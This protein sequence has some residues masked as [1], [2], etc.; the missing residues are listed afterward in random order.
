MH[1]NVIN[2]SQFVPCP[3][4]AELR[5]HITALYKITRLCTCKKMVHLEFT[6]PSAI[7]FF[8]KNLQKLLSH[9]LYPQLKLI[10][11]GFSYLQ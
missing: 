4:I 10:L 2:C 8:A 3:E 7:L 1:L 5:L 11:E 9:P 6:I